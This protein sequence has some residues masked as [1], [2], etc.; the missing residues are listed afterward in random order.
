[1]VKSLHDEMILYL[2]KIKTFLSHTLLGVC[3]CLQRWQVVPT[4]SVLLC[5]TGDWTVFPSP[6]EKAFICVSPEPNEAFLWL[7][8]CVFHMR[9]WNVKSLPSW[10]SLLR[11]D[12]SYPMCHLHFKYHPFPP[13]IP[14]LCLFLFPFSHLIY[15]ILPSVLSFH[16]HTLTHKLGDLFF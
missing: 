7:R 1:M 9:L 3:H 16:T 8:V 5:E 14:S 2:L 11:R 6:P 10:E 13:W 12:G 15:V 4:T